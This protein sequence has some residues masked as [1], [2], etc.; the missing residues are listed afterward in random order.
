MPD[1]QK[2]TWAMDGYGSPIGSLRGALNIHN[3]DVHQTPINHYFYQ[4]LGAYTLSLPINAQDS[5]MT[6]T[7]VTGIVAGSRL[8][9][10]DSS[11]L[12]HDHDLLLVI[13]VVGNVVSVNR[14][15]DKAYAVAT[16]SVTRVNID[17]NTSGTVAAPQVYTLLPSPGEVWHLTSMDF[18]MTDA[19]AMDDSTFG[20]LVQLTNGVVVRQHDV[21][22]NSYETFSHWRYNSAFNVDGFITNYASKAPSGVYGYS[23]SL[24]F[25]QRYESIV[26]LANTATEVVQMEVLV[27]DNLTGLSTF[28]MKVHGHIETS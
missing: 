20:G 4:N 19:T 24:D 1:L 14:P 10:T 6:L 3:A 23:G 12:N 13:S 8:H 16:T 28:R 18:S 26:R 27:Q 9:L 22:N 2:P 5:S 7:S 11:N 17:I 25:N 21:M 15:I